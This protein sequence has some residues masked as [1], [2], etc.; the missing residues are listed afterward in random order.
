[1]APIK[2]VPRQ[3]LVFHLLAGFGLQQGSYPRPQIIVGMRDSQLR[4]F[5]VSM[6]LPYHRSVG[7]QKQL[8]GKGFAC[9]LI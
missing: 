7:Q 8:L 9:C 1:M 5:A 2:F 4:R 6:H 3:E